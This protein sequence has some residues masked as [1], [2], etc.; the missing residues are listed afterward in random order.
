MRY[1]TINKFSKIVGVTA[2]TLRNWDKSGRLKPHHTSRSGYRYYSEEQLN[3]ILEIKPKKKTV[4]GYCRVSSP[5]QKDD[6]TR[7]IDN[8]KTYLLAQGKPFEIISDIGSGI[9]CRRKGLLELIE[10]ISK[11]EIEKV[12]VLYKD[13]LSRF[14]FELIE[15]VASL[16]GCEIEVVDNTQKTEQEELVEDL[17]QI[18]T[19][20]SCKLQGRRA[21]K[22]RKLIKELVDGEQND[23]VV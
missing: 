21:N 8:L 15:Y 9:N 5:K 14:G 1:Y 10:R 12:V 13:R 4:I 22:A 23:E 19:V 18:I 11:N 6:L 2:Q 7:Q 3:Q 16:Y 20:F 17:V